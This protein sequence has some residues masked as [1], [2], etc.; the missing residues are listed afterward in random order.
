MYLV[1]PPLTS[2]QFTHALDAPS[3]LAFS[4]YFCERTPDLAQHILRDDSST[5][6]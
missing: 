2:S 1:C 4:K 6:L 5:H 3:L